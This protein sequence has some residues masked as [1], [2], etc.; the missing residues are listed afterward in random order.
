M[1]YAT[2]IELTNSLLIVSP[3]NQSKQFDLH[4]GIN[5]CI[6]RLNLSFYSA[7]QYMLSR[8]CINIIHCSN[9]WHIPFDS[10]NFNAMNNDEQ[11]A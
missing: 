1:Q 9:L 5:K 2:C 8:R 10:R 4:T 6:F 7:R 11:G 3:D